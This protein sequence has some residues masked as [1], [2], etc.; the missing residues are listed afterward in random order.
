MI[1]SLFHNEKNRSSEV[2]DPLSMALSLIPQLVPGRIQIS[3]QFKSKLQC[4]MKSSETWWMG[5]T[6]KIKLKPGF[7]LV[8]KV[9]S[10]P[11][12][13]I[14]LIEMGHKLAVSCL[15]TT[16]KRQKNNKF[17]VLNYFSHRRELC[18]F[19]QKLLILSLHTAL[20][21]SFSASKPTNG[22]KEIGWREAIA[23]RHK[24]PERSKSQLELRSPPPP[25]LGMI[26]L[27]A[28]NTPVMTLNH[29]V[30]IKVFSDTI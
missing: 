16:D 5:K 21:N 11:W 15:V 13:S 9:K 20:T 28:T 27:T 6:G 2:W 19:F 23:K 14:Y 12:N 30:M 3:L 10:M 24:L 7:K 25:F 26:L 17:H 29:Q 18:D 4:R 8:Q 22:E 1:W